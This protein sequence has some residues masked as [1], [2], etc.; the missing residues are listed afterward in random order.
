[1]AYQNVRIEEQNSYLI[2]DFTCSQP[3]SCNGR[4]SN[5]A[6]TEFDQTWNFQ[7]ISYFSDVLVDFD[8]FNIKLQFLEGNVT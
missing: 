2:L 1:M 7:P 3:T 4:F 8:D 5:M 6:A